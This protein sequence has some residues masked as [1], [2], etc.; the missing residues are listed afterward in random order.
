MAD[1]PLGNLNAEQLA[2]YNKEGKKLLVTFEDI[3]KVVSSNAKTASDFTEKSVKNY[4][5]SNSVAKKLSKTLAGLTKEQLIGLDKRKKFEKDLKDLDSEIAARKATIRNLEEDIVQQRALTV[6]LTQAVAEEMAEGAGAD[7]KKIAALNAQIDLSKEK[8]SA[9]LDSQEALQDE[10]NEAKLLKSKYKEILDT[11]REMERVNPFTGISE[12][13]GDIPVIGKLFKGLS[14]AASTFNK[15]LAKAPDHLTEAQKRT[16]AL[17]KTFNELNKDAL[18]ASFAF[19]GKGAVEAFNAFDEATVKLE[20]NLNVS[21][22]KAAELQQGFIRTAKAYQGIVSADLNKALTEANASLGTTAKLSNDTLA[23]HVTLTKQMGFSADEASQLMKFAMA[24]GQDFKTMTENAA[25]T[26]KVLNAQ[27]GTAIDYK[28]ILKDIN[29]TSNQV[30]MSLEA[31]GFSL[32]KAAFEAKK[33][34]LSLDQMD[35]I[36]GNL[37]NFEQSIADELEAELLLGRDLNLEKARQKALDG[38]LVGMSKELMNQGITAKKFNSM[39]RIEQES[40]AKAMGMQRGEMAN[41]FAEQEALTA[42][43]IEGA[44]NLDDAVN[45]KYDSIVKAKE[46]AIKAAKESGESEEEI[47]KRINDAKIAAQKELG[48]LAKETGKQELIDKRE[49]QTAAEIKDELQTK[50]FENLALAFD[51][52]TFA[53]GKKAFGALAGEVDLLTAATIA[54]TAVQTAIAGMDLFEKFGGRRRGRGKSKVDIDT[55]SV[56]KKLT[57]TLDDSI[58]DVGK[59]LT[60]TL[61]D[62]IDDVGKKFT[63]T[64][65]DATSDVASKAAS[66]ADDVAKAGASSA[67]D[68]AKAGAKGGIFGKMFSGAKSLAGKAAGAVKGVAGKAA[69]VAGK[70]VGAVGNVAGKAAG[71]VK[72]VAGKAA[73]MAGKAL[74]AVNPMSAIKKFFK[75]GGVGKLLKKLPGIGALIGPVIAGYEIAQ[76]VGATGGEADPRN[77]GNATLSALGGLGGGALGSILGSLIGPGIGTFLGG[78]AGDYIGRMVA[79]LIAENI[80]MSGLGKMAINIFGGSAKQEAPPQM[81]GGAEIAPEMAADFISRPGQPIQTFRPDDVVIG[82]TNPMGGGGDDGRTIELLER[83][84]AAVEKGGVI[85]MDGNKVGTMLGMSSYRTQ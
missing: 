32:E 68:V 23:T 40:I 56:G 26:V 50:A 74:D 47:A 82:G 34:G 78:L 53:G 51:P 15:E 28:Q 39:N 5:S 25:G 72:G 13:I 76:E 70:A 43:Q 22:V 17:R 38:D 9:I 60:D 66:V 44:E 62:S 84:V 64:M 21:T 69:G 58:D 83:L 41:M 12:I 4:S 1:T 49:A 42:L 14:G 8:T 24:T 10:Q 16:R 80:D 31:Q 18:K 46:E 85:N 54:L 27:N 57:N 61:D 36:A 71:A 75:G 55:K 3:G 33:M 67:D 52:E 11:T 37:L 6:S 48:K 19:M 59:K 63:K 20:K 81:A 35:S 29:S 65:G 77:V 79:D 7:Q 2:E 45:M 30:K 73:G